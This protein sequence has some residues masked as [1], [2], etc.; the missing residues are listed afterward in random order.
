[1]WPLDM[2]I[3]ETKRRDIEVSV[4]CSKC[5]IDKPADLLEMARQYG[6][7]A[8]LINLAPACDNCG[9][10]VYLVGPLSGQSTD[11]RALRDI[12]TMWNTAGQ[13]RRKNGSTNKMGKKFTEKDYFGLMKRIKDGAHPQGSLSL[14]DYDAILREMRDFNYIEVDSNIS[15]GRLDHIRILGKGEGFYDSIINPDRVTRS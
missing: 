13:A 11:R 15:T 3:S 1:M 10:K 2:A 9:E 4:C 8:T 14:E 7:K 6:E 5:R 12:G